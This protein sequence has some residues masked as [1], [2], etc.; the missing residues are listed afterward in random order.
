VAKCE[1]ERK[2]HVAES[3]GGPVELTGEHVLFIKESQYPVDF[4]CLR[5]S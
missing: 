2:E 5:G 3:Q 1:V 4:S